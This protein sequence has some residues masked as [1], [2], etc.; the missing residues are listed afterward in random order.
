MSFATASAVQYANPSTND[1][2]FDELRFELLHDLFVAGAFHVDGDYELRN[3]ERSTFYANLRIKSR[4]KMIGGKPCSGA[5]DES[6][7]ARST[8][9]LYR[10]LIKHDVPFAAL[11][12]VPYG[13]N[14]LAEG[15]ANCHQTI[16]GTRPSIIHFEKT[17]RQVT[18]LIGDQF[19]TRQDKVLLVEDTITTGQSVE[20]ALILYNNRVM[21]Q[22]PVP[23]VVAMLDRNAGAHERLAQHGAQVIA[24]FTLEEVLEFGNHQ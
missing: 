15:I 2:K 20:E 18:A 23:Y 12:P 5:L 3:G 8:S 11:C 10:L 22:T 7:L 21:C 17:G 19:I 4:V 6:L 24:L 9:L 16:T 13:G 1:K 14:P